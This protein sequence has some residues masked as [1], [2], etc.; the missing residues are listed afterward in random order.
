MALY[1][2]DQYVGKNT[3]EIFDEVNHPGVAAPRSGIYRCV[4]CGRED[5]ST[6]G[7]PLPPQNH[8][9]HTPA[10]GTIRWR[11]AVYADHKPKA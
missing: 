3:D 5:V 1:K 2:Y 11:L 7:H 6:E 9:Q 10:Q 4:G 8:H